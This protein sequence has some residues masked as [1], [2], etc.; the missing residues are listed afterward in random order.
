MQ[1]YIFLLF[2]IFEILVILQINIKVRIG[3]N[4]Y[5]NNGKFL[6]TIFGFKILHNTFSFEKGFIKITNNKGKISL[7]PI[8]LTN[9]DTYDYMGLE[10]ILFKKIY[11]KRL[12]CYLNFGSKESSF[13]TSLVIGTSRAICLSASSFIKSKKDGLIT[14]IKI[15]PVYN[16]NYLKINLKTSASIS[17][18]DF[19]WC[20][21]EY[22]ATKKKEGD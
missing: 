22:K 16:K 15:Y 17:I 19:I 2:L 4:F 3:Y 18:F 14:T 21:G 7:L 5:T 8:S 11:L 1:G 6:L 13:A 20:F 9:P 12:N 10:T